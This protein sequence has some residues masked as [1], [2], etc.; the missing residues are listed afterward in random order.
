MYS[1][2][3]NLI[4]ID[5]PEH[6]S[7][8]SWKMAP[9]TLYLDDTSEALQNF[10]ISN[11]WANKKSH[12][13][14]SKCNLIISDGAELLTE[15]NSTERKSF[16]TLPLLFL[17]RCKRMMSTSGRYTRHCGDVLYSLESICNRLKLLRCGGKRKEDKKQYCE[18]NGKVRNW[19]RCSSHDIKTNAADI[20]LKATEWLGLLTTS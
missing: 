6:S 16:S 8:P 15:G 19:K 14:E 5:A 2:K 18:V 4:R 12:E 1:S 10:P 17:V 11:S 20:H 7:S 3:N 9:L 13:Q